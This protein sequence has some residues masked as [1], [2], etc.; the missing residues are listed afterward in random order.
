MRY[1]KVSH[2]IDK[3]SQ[4]VVHVCVLIALINHVVIPLNKRAYSVS[5]MLSLRKCSHLFEFG[6]VS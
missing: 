2:N 5:H 3:Q 6:A 4:A 1:F